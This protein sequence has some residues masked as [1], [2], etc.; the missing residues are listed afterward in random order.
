MISDSSFVVNAGLSDGSVEDSSTDQSVPKDSSKSSQFPESSN[1]SK[2][3]EIDQFIKS[4]IGKGYISK[5]TFFE[6]GNTKKPMLMYNIKNFN[7]CENVQRY[8]KS[9]TI[10]YVADINRLVVYQKCHKC[11]GFRS[12]DMVIANK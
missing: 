11:S 3:P 2:F 1:S 8:H 6:N 9:N 7:Y 5:K 10:Y 12:P 4:L